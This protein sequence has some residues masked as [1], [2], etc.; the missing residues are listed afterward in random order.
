MADRREYKYCG[1]EHEPQ[2][3]KEHNSPLSAQSAM[4]VIRM[5]WGVGRFHVG[6]HF[7]KRCSERGLDTL[8]IENLIRNG[9]VRGDAEYC[10]EYKTWKY[11]VAGVIE[12]RHM[13]VLIALDPTEDYADSP[14]AILITAYERKP[15][16]KP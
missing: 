6:T 9:A 14:L 5:A 7:K 8:D 16:S 1:P 15:G 12:E 2:R 10:P 11:R 3:V 4:S 13:E